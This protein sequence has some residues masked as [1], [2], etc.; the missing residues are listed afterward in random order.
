M[1]EE[2]FCYLSPFARIFRVAESWSWSTTDGLYGGCLS[3]KLH[4]LCVLCWVCSF[5]S[6]LSC[7]YVLHLTKPQTHPL[8]LAAFPFLFTNYPLFTFLQPF[9]VNSPLLI[10]FFPLLLNISCL[11]VGG[12][13]Y[14]GLTADFLGRDS[15]IFRSMGG[16]STMRTETDQKLLHGN[17]SLF[18]ERFYNT[19]QC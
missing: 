4:S 10:I 6:F 11:S 16:R 15:V 7:I 9:S 5:S 17:V 3:F 12:E 19:R 1:L 14:T 2:G 13:L 8:F 18:P